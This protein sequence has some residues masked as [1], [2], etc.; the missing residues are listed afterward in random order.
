MTIETIPKLSACR[1]FYTARHNSQSALN[2]NSAVM[3]NHAKIAN[4]AN[5]L[6]DAQIVGLSPPYIAGDG[7]PAS[8]YVIRLNGTS[9]QKITIPD[10][11]NFIF[12]NTFTQICSFIPQKTFSG[13]CF[14][15]AKWGDYAIEY[16]DGIVSSHYSGAQIKGSN[17]W[18][19]KAGFR[20]D[21]S[22]IYDD[23]NM[24]LVMNGKNIL[25]VPVTG[26][27]DHTS[28]NFSI[29]GLNNTPVDVL[30]YAF[31]DTVLSLPEIARVHKIFDANTQ[32][33][34]NTIS[35]QNNTVKTIE[36]KKFLGLNW[37]DLFD[38]NHSC[39][40]M[41]DGNMLPGLVK[42]MQQNKCGK[43]RYPGGRN[44]AF[45]F[46]LRID[47]TTPTK[48]Q[49]AA[50][51]VAWK[52]AK[53]NLPYGDLSH[54]FADNFVDFFEFCDLLKNTGLQACIQLN[55]HTYIDSNNVIQYFKAEDRSIDWTIVDKGADIA[56]FQVQYVQNMGISHLVRW[57][58]GNEDYLYR[59]EGY[60]EPGN[61]YI[62]GYL[63]SEYARIADIFLQKI[64][65]L[66]P[67][68][69]VVLTADYLVLHSMWDYRKQNFVQSMI[70]SP[71]FEKYKN[72]PRI[73][74]SN[75]EYAYDAFTTFFSGTLTSGSNLITNIKIGGQN[76]NPL[77][78]QIKDYL[79][80]NVYITA[81]KPL[82]GAMWET[83]DY[84]AE[85]T[86]IAEVVDNTTLRMS[87]NAL[88][89]GTIAIALQKNSTDVNLTN[90]QSTRHWYYLPDNVLK[91]FSTRPPVRNESAPD[92][93]SYL[94]AQG[95]ASPKITVNEYNVDAA[96]NR[97]MSSWMLALNKAMMLMGYA[98]MPAVTD[99]Y[100]HLGVN[101]YN[102]DDDNYRNDSYGAIH[103]HQND[104]ALNSL[105]HFIPN[106]EVELYKHIIRD[107]RKNILP[108]Q[109]NNDDLWTLASTDG[110][111]ISLVIAN[112]FSDKTVTLSLGDF[113]GMELLSHKILG[114]SHALTDSKIIRY[115]SAK[116]VR[117][118]KKLNTDLLSKH[119]TSPTNTFSADLKANTLNIFRF[120]TTAEQITTSENVS[121][122][123]LS[124][125]IS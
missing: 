63:G 8:P 101:V 61:T 86:T 6:E 22:V 114:R 3:Y 91:S 59:D 45:S 118:I 29:L 112:I 120:K 53:P 69:Q 70:N 88:S 55:N 117:R 15:I 25:R 119:S 52:T 57:E 113:S 72:D 97:Y 124:L 121:K 14:Q 58:I 98:K 71:Y 116:N 68:T 78:Q 4:T 75:H 85:N 32:A 37:M 56:A 17:S 43:M 13:S 24:L 31:Y 111:Y 5:A 26:V 96:S 64:F 106:Y 92:L 90:N 74:Y 47:G 38:P 79:N 89:S 110:K 67:E 81:Y 125:A 73:I 9:A 33:P 109:L 50:A 65:A 93:Y 107:L 39:K 36:P 83:K 10:S 54:T 115:D 2:A 94:V 82:W 23:S 1:G 60:S 80:S 40:K 104:V 77:L 11:P 95:I 103:F 41:R 19:I 49:Q 21:L 16:N 42:T 7:T 34:H 122:G 76:D 18:A 123:L 28:A 102:T 44:V 66:N 105:P 20:Y 108:V 35:V 51:I 30:G 27:F 62:H 84:F 48:A 99:V 100:Q 12:G 87:G 46:P